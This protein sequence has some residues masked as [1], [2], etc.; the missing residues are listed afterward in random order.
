MKTMDY[1]KETKSNIET[2]GLL[3]LMNLIEQNSNIYD[4][5]HTVPIEDLLTR[6]TVLELNAIDNDEQKALIIALVLASAC[7]HIKTI[8]P[9]TG[10]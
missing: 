2:A 8:R 4:T 6:P 10:N 3:R 7:I 5:I 1:N 9:V